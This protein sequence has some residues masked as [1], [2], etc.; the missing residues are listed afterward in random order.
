M[1]A[2]AIRMAADTQE[3]RVPISPE[4]EEL[5][6]EHALGAEL[7]LAPGE[8]TWMLNQ[9]HRKKPKAVIAS[10]VLDIESG[11]WILQVKDHD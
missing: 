7:V 1:L 4:Q 2:G 8:R 3:V 9:L 6:F 10:A 5:L 11:E